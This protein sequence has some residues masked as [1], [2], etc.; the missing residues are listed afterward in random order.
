MRVDAFTRKSRSFNEDDYGFTK[1]MFWVIDGATPRTNNLFNNFGYNSNAE[2]FAKTL[3]KNLYKYTYNNKPLYDIVRSALLDT[4]REFEEILNISVDDIEE[5]LQPG[6]S[7]SIVKLN[8]D[9]AELLVIGDTLLI[10]KFESDRYYI[11]YGDEMHHKLDDKITK[12][13]MQ[14]RKENIP[15]EDRE[16]Q[17]SEFIL[18]IRKK[19]QNKEGGYPELNISRVSEDYI[20]NK[21]NYFYV[22]ENE[23]PTEILLASDGFY[24]LVTTFRVYDKFEDLLYTVK[25][26]GTKKMV[27]MVYDYSILYDI[28]TIPRI[29]IFDDTTALYIKPKD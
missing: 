4:R 9:S 16:K 15:D 25:V 29:K 27:N 3:S 26:H 10:S 14:K 13:I 18:S 21:K 23:W 22:K 28:D 6:G 17:I 2:W 11:Y 24:S 19:Y 1:N 8:E 5:H 20:F 12:F 7:I